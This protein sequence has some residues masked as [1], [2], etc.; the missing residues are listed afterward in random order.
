MKSK[1]YRITQ[2]ISHIICLIF[3]LCAILPLLLLI[4]GSFTDNSWAVANGFSFLPGKWS[5]EAYRY[6][7]SQ[8]AMI[9]HGYLMTFI[10]TGLGTILGLAISTLFAYGISQKDVPGM[11]LFSFLLIFTMLFNGGLV[12]TYYSYINFFHIKDTIWALIV[13]NFLMN[14]F[15]VILIRNYFT[16]S[17]PPSLR[18]A[19]VIDGAGEF[20]VFLSIVLPLSKPILAT[21]GLLIGLTY[22]NDWTNGLYYLTKRGGSDLYTIQNI[23]NNINE[24]IQALMQSS[25][26]GS[27]L[28]TSASQLP[29][30]T[31]RMAIAVIGML[32][33]VIMYPFFQKYFVKGITLG[34]VK[35]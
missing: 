23:L 35:E 22:W 31:V 8:W 21:V 30:T 16:N 10:V 25:S 4:I 12:A 2:V 26:S 29:S 9:G 15:N 14:A 11:K 34:G 7:Q 3:A 19:A 32:P 5:A 20:R 27:Q 28:G 24:N 1:E 13:P 33:V 18:E 6:I 17:I